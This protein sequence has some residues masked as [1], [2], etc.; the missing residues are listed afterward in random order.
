ML[1]K[2]PASDLNMACTF[3]NLRWDARDPQSIRRWHRAF[4]HRLRVISR[5]VSRWEPGQ[6]G[7]GNAPATLP[8]I[9]G[10]RKAEAL[11]ADH[12]RVRHNIGAFLLIAVLSVLSW[13]A[14]PEA[15]VHKRVSEVQLT[16]VATDQNGRPLTNL[17]P[18]DI[19]VLEDG[20]PVPRF[21]LRTAADLRLR[22]AIVLDLSDSTRKSWPTVRA[23]LARSL[24]EVM[25][26]ED[27]LFVLAFNSK[28]EW[29]HKLA[30]PAALETVWGDPGRGGLTA[31]YDTIYQ[32]CGRA[33]FA[34][35]REPH[36]SALV[37]FSDGEDD[38]SLHAL[39]DAIARAQRA[40][41]AIYT[42]ATHN[43]KKKTYGDAVLHGLATATGGRDFIVRDAQQ[44]EK[45]LADINSELRSSYLLYYRASEQPGGRAFRRVHV[46]STQVGGARVR[47]RAGY[48][49]AP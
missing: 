35:D 21:E 20:Q 19:T 12:Q 49:T 41:V 29:E 3:S 16:L 43:P 31:L 40:G 15:V 47:S 24:G 10:A 4:L 2:Q 14:E 36:R 44:L 6:G 42:V 27:E 45:A 22:V 32:A 13:A 18:A 39:E 11:G 5:F 7:D 48:F 9:G 23:A 37:L 28:I 30:N 26:P 34:A 17:S 33:L 8:R 38:L 46:I 25:R 1:P